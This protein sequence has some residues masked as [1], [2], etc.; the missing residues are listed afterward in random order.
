MA[1]DECRIYRLQQIFHRLLEND[2]IVRD[3]VV[4]H[5]ISPFDESYE[6]YPRIAILEHAI[7]KLS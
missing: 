3:A 4:L 2:A 5:D 1:F 7:C 6:L